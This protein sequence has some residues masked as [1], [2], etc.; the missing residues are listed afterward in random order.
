MGNKTE[1]NELCQL[2]L[3]E[4]ATNVAISTCSCQRADIIRVSCVARKIGINKV[5][6]RSPTNA[7][8]FHPQRNISHAVH[9]TYR[10]TGDDI[11]AIPTKFLI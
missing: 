2:K 3:T 10:G 6:N 8:I 1:G 9:I 4:G 11:Q 7:C 5:W